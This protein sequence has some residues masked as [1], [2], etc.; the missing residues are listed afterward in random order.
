MSGAP[1][2]GSSNFTTAS[3]IEDLSSGTIRDVLRAQP[4]GGTLRHFGGSAL[5]SEP[6]RVTELSLGP[7]RS[8]ATAVMLQRTRDALKTLD[9]WP[10]FGVGRGRVLLSVWWLNSGP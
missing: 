10:I 3:L 1:A 9:F 5:Y 8:V 7:R 4:V 6:P 2:T